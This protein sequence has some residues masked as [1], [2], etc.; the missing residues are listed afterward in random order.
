M[1]SQNPEEVADPSTNQRL[2][3]ESP[4]DP[5]QVTPPNKDMNGRILVKTGVSAIR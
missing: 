2:S 3:S 1:R 4:E 5:S